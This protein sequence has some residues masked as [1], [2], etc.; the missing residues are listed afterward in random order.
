MKDYFTVQRR[1]VRHGA[2]ARDIGKMTLR[3]MLLAGPN[4]NF[5]MMDWTDR[6]CRAFYRLCE[7][8]RSHT[9]SPL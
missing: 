3:Y 1:T 6:H 2:K 9:T 8:L 4:S 5:T 7:A